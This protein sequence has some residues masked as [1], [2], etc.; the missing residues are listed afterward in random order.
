LKAKILQVRLRQGL[1]AYGKASEEEKDQ[2]IERWKKMEC[3]AKFGVRDWSP[4][5]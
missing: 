3:S 2:V 4:K 5:D 1:V